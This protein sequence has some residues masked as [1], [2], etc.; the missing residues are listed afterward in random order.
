MMP[1]PGIE[2]AAIELQ[3]QR[4]NHGY[5]ATSHLQAT[6]PINDGHLALS[7]HSSN[8]PCELSQWLAMM[9]AP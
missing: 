5:G 3:V 2:L 9:A 4:S 6:E 7:M 8:E 1:R